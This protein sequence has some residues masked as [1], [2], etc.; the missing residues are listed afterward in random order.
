MQGL[1]NKWLMQSDMILLKEYKPVILRFYELWVYIG[2][3]TDRCKKMCMCSKQLYS[4][5]PKMFDIAYYSFSPKLDEGEEHA[6]MNHL[7]FTDR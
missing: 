4:Q 5:F 7:D 1:G 6:N 2:H 3:G